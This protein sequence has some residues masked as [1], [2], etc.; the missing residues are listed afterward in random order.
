MYYLKLIRESLAQ[1][2][3]RATARRG[4]QH[5]HRK[6][7]QYLD[8]GFDMRHGVDTCQPLSIHDLDVDASLKSDLVGYEAAPV[9]VV[10]RLLRALPVD[11]A[12]YTFID[13]GS[14]KG[15]VLLLA[16]ELPFRKVIGVELSRSL[17]DVAMRNLSQWKGRSARCGG[18]ESLHLNATEYEPPSE[19]LVIFFYT[20]F[21]EPVM[22]QV[23]SR[24]RTWLSAHEHGLYL[25]YYGSR[26]ELCRHFESLG[27]SHRELFM[28]RSWLSTG[29]YTA[30][31]YY[32]DQAQ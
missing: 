16:S 4:W 22:K 6:A 18:L 32:R 27:L 29:R 26:D 13:Y 20:P 11:P 12:E 10:R 8:L 17:H 23:L 30:H 28:T 1:E 25:L 14:G 3:V 5:L 7:V 9:R 24:I 19:P 31:L 2:G 21:F 15:R